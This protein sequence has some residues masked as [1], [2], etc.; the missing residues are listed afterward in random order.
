MRYCWLALVGWLLSGGFL[1]AQQSGASTPPA[2]TFDPAHNRLDSYLV[3]WEEKMKSVTSLAADIVQEKDDQVFRTRDVYVGKAK[4]LKPN[5][6]MLYLQKK[7]RPDVFQKYICT[8][9][10]LYEYNQSAREL[11]YHELPAPK[12]GQVADDNFLGF[13][14]GMRAEDARRRYDMRLMGEDQYYVY[15]EVLPRTAADAADFHKAQLAF[16][17]NTMLP[18]QLT[19]EEPNKNRVKWD[20]PVIETGLRLDRNEFTRPDLPP[21]WK[22]VRG[23]RAE[24]QT[25]GV[26]VPPRVV[27][28]N[29][30]P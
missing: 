25:K 30:D 19:F 1:P 14:F 3:Q 17:K 27:R 29:Q 5:L 9:S 12:P 24:Q 10:F 7:S 21:G 11:R 18:R 4:Y 16:T 6:A 23:K 20:I 13:L 28:P 2:A 26:Q 22:L 15:V 8:G